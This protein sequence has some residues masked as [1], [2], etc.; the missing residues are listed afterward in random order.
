MVHAFISLIYIFTIK[1]KSKYPQWDKNK[2]KVEIIN[3]PL[4]GNYKNIR[5]KKIIIS[6]FVEFLECYAFLLTK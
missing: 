1:A 6:D 3:R 2:K 4:N 5:Y